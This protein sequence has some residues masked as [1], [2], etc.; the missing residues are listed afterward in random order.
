LNFIAG[1]AGVC[2]PSACKRILLP[3]FA[4]GPWGGMTAQFSPN[5]ASNTVIDPSMSKPAPLVRLAQ[6][7]DSCQPERKH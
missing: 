5:T 3:P 6:A 1:A 4:A 7:D 2:D